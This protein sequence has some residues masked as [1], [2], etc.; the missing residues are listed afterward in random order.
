MFKR[1]LFVLIIISLSS[2]VLIGCSDSDDDTTGPGD[3][4]FPATYS[5]TFRFDGINIDIPFEFTIWTRENV[6][7][8]ISGTDDQG[9]YYTYTITGGID[10]YTLTMNLTGEYGPPPCAVSGSFMGT[11]DED[12]AQFTGTWIYETCYGVTFTGTWTAA[13]Q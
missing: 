11:S 7:G 5:G 12:Y 10:E 4:P 6:S 2:G 8:T 3:D 1:I 9:N 13:R